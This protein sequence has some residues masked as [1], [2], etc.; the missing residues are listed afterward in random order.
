MCLYLC[1]TDED[2]EDGGRAAVGPLQVL[3]ASVFGQHPS[4]DRL[5]EL[6]T[7]A[8]LPVAV[9]LVLSSPEGFAVAVHG[10]RLLLL[11]VDLLHRCSEPSTEKPWDASQTDH[12]GIAS[13]TPGCFAQCDTKHYSNAS[14]LLYFQK[15]LKKVSPF[16]STS[17]ND[18]THNNQ[19]K[20]IDT[21]SSILKRKGKR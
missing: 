2:D 16:K 5:L 4:G 10:E 7:A 14:D 6:L 18:K 13:S 11:E 19:N 21:I 20:Y 8:H 1:N 3:A 17:T 15:Y 12:R 9:Q